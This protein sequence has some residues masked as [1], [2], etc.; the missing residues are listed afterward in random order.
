MHNNDGTNCIKLH[1]SLRN[2][3][4]SLPIIYDIDDTMIINKI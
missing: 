4:V 3:N 2:I 1:L